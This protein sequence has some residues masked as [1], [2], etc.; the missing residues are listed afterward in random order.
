MKHLKTKFEQNGKVLRLTIHRPEVRNAFNEVLIEEY[1]SVFA[2]I[3]AEEGEYAKVQVVLLKGE[4]PSFCGGGD[5]NWMKKSLD[6]SHEENIEDCQKLTHMFHTMDRCPVPLVGLVHGHAIGGG[7][8]LVSVCDHVIA[9]DSTVFSL[10][11]VKL[12]L[13][14]ACIGPFVI[15]KIGPSQARSLFVS[16]ERFKADKALRIGLVHE[17]CSEA[18]L[19]KRGDEVVARILEGGPVAIESA[20]FLIHTLSREL[21]REDFSKSLEFAAAELAQLR[22]QP[23]AQEGVRAFLEKRTPS[24]RKG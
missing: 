6:L 10:S 7:V 9:A 24:W 13:I 19:D 8:G 23:E 5:L 21:N 3:T 2:A 17:V 15:G 14:P 12:G 20:K 18:E 22:V 16:G 4:G 11:E 1:R